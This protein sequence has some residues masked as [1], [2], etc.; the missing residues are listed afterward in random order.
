M[1]RDKRRKGQRT[2]KKLQ[3]AEATSARSSQASARKEMVVVGK[4]GS[5]KGAIR[6]GLTSIKARAS[7][8]NGESNE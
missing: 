4:P 3:P 1:A 8:R 6:F 2:R 5:G 7:R